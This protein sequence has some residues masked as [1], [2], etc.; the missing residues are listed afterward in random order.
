MSAWAQ[1]YIDAWNRHSARDVAGHMTPDAV[2]VD[3]TLGETFRGPDEIGH[4]AELMTETFSS[5]YRFEL[6][7]AIVTQTDFA[8]EWT[9]RGTH[10][11]ASA[12]LP[13]TG[14][15]F[16]IRGVSVG[17]LRNGQISVNRDYW[18]LAD[19]LTQVGLMPQPEAAALPVP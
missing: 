1:Q 19:F 16:A 12:E 7:N 2:F 9:L 3:T 6:T 8:L 13:A 10:D 11:R 15:S 18:N 5:D 17:S 14:K 4:W